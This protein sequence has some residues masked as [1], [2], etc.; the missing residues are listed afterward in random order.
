MK[1]RRYSYYIHIQFL[2]TCRYILKFTYI[3]WRVFFYW[4]LLLAGKLNVDLKFPSFLSLRPQ[5][6]C[7]QHSCILLPR[8]PSWIVFV[9]C[10]NIVSA[11]LSG[12]GTLKYRPIQG[13]Y[14]F[15]EI[16][17]FFNLVSD[18]FVSEISQKTVSTIDN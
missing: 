5:S 7:R 2:P 4:I 12:G 16:F 6:S 3:F 14:F 18:F 11:T 1:F 8:V 10:I 9:R 13:I 17:S 15:D